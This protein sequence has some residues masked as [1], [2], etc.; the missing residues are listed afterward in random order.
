M[1]ILII[2]FV[3][4][5]GGGGGGGLKIFFDSNVYNIKSDHFSPKIKQYI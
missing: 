5:E 3:G 2:I 4:G 1:S